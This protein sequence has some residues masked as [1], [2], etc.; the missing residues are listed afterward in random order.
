MSHRFAR[1]LA[2]RIEMFAVVL[3][4]AASVVAAGAVASCGGGGSGGSS[5]D[6]SACAATPSDVGT[7]STFIAF[8]GNFQNY[9]SWQSFHLDDGDAGAQG[10]VHLA[11]PKTEYL[12]KKPPSGS[13]EFPVGTVIVKELEI[14]PLESRKVFAMVK[15]GGGFNAASTAPN[16]EWFELQNN[17]DGSVNNIVWRGFGPPAGEQYGGDPAGCT[18]CHAAAKDND[19][20]PSAPLQLKTLAP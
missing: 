4:S 6:P 15:R 7:N 16:W 18:N 17:A 12:N 13:K 19:D 8:C 3:F 20:V 11:G 2:P 14:G 9:R 10:A 1:S 5:S